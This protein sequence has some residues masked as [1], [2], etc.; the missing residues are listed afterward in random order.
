MLMS[1]T[2]HPTAR[3]NPGAVMPEPA[4]A[5][6]RSGY[7]DEGSD[8]ESALTPIAIRLLV[9][10]REERRLL[11]LASQ[12]RKNSRSQASFAVFPESGV[13]GQWEM[14]PV[15][16]TAM[17]S[18]ASSAARR[19]ASPSVQARWRGASG[20]PWQLM[21]IGTTGMSYCGVKN[22]AGP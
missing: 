16:T 21:F 19:S 15:P 2:V 17:R 11:Q 1:A 6:R 18:G 13:A 22:A 20:G 3:Q 12:R 4:T 7:G 5:F 14:P 10:V 8:L 9:A